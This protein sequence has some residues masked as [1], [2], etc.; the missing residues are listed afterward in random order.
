VKNLN[1]II[2]LT[3][4]IL[5]LATAANASASFDV[6]S[7]SPNPTTCPT[8]TGIY[9]LTVENTGTEADKYT[10][11]LSGDSS[12]WAISAPSGFALTPGAVKQVYIYITPT[13]NALI[14]DYDLNIHVVGQIAGEKVVTVPIAINSCHSATLSTEKSEAEVCSCTMAKYTLELENTGKYTENFEITA[15]GSAAKWTSLS[16]EALTLDAGEKRAIYVYSTPDCDQT[17]QYDLTITAK[18]LNSNALASQ[19][20]SL[21]SLAC[22]DTIL[23]PQTEYISLCEN[24]EKN[25][26]IE[27]RNDGTADNIYTLSVSGPAWA[28]LETSQVELKA[29]KSKE[30]NLVLFPKYK[31]SGEFELNLKAISKVGDVNVQKKIIANVLTCHNTDLKISAVEDTLCPYVNKTYIVTLMNIGNYSEKYNIEVTGA[32]W[33]NIEE[34]FIE[35]DANESKELELVA[36]PDTIEG[37]YIIKIKA[38]SQYECRTE[39]SDVLKITVPQ[40]DA[41]YGVAVTPEKGNVDV[42]YGEAAMIPVLI[43]NKGTEESTFTLD[44]SGTGANYIQLNP[45]TVTVAGKATETVYLYAAVPEDT[46]HARYTLTVTART[47]ENTIYN[48]ADVTLTVVSAE[49]LKPVSLNEAG[50]KVTGMVSGVKSGASTVGGSFGKFKD[51]VYT[52]Y[53][54]FRDWIWTGLKGNGESGAGLSAFLLASPFLVANWIWII[55]ILAAMAVVII[56]WKYIP[57]SDELEKQL[58]K[59]QAE[60]EAE[61]NKSGPKQEE[62]PEAEPAQDAEKSKKGIWS[63]FKDFLDEDEKD[64]KIEDTKEEINIEPKASEEPKEEKKQ[65]PEKKPK[66]KK[67]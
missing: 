42:A 58:E 30:I 1:K 67:K 2:L 8:V 36:K 15:S 17:G 27:L 24:T 47:A 20:L 35:L 5:C 41:C 43:E 50:E 54:G 51:A 65:K 37:N 31:V 32:N 7:V 10:V 19:N 4:A 45:A 53:T 59:I 56:A 55:I 26:S 48:S 23:E 14:G 61:L 33:A 21:N 28:T 12:T 57:D 62:I 25:I 6:N 29:G 11:T 22:Y 63:R 38:T 40:S 52:K 49:E 44:I 13:L 46:P 34:N 60:H 39:A 16:E 9:V 64:F 66:G 3:I 18:S